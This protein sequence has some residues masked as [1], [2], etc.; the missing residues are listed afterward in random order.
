MCSST[1]ESGANRSIHSEQPFDDRVDELLQ[2]V[3]KQQRRIDYLADTLSKIDGTRISVEWSGSLGIGGNGARQ[4]STVPCSH[5]GK[6]GLAPGGGA[7]TLDG[8][9]TLYITEHMPDQNG[10]AWTTQVAHQADP[11]G[12]HVRF[13]A[14]CA[15]K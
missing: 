11:G 15:Y 1:D 10:H 12:G 4:N 7:I 9:Q 8:R 6:S 2:S 13:F 5:E 14:I 3:E